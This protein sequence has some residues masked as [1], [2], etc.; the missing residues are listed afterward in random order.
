ML[1][2]WKEYFT[3]AIL[4]LSNPRCTIIA[5]L[6]VIYTKFRRAMIAQ[7]NKIWHVWACVCAITCYS[8]P[9]L[10]QGLSQ[11]CRSWGSIV[12]MQ[13]VLSIT[14]MLVGLSVAIMQVTVYVAIRQLEVFAA[15][16]HAGY[17]FQSEYVGDNFYCNYAGGTLCYNYADCNFCSTL[18]M[19]L[20]LL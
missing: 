10:W 18:C 16:M 15:L 6:N 12:I 3:C 8:W 7:L 9:C 2:I 19:W 17:S 20:S 14:V 5:C 1:L 4:L 11:L 13:V